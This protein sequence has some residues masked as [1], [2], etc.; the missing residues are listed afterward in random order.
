MGLR[1]RS[2]CVLFITILFFISSTAS[3]QDGVTVTTFTPPPPLGNWSICGPG[4]TFTIE[5]AAL[6]VSTGVQMT[7]EL[8]PGMTY[9]AN[10]LSPAATSEN[11]TN[12]NQPVF[13]LPDYTVPGEMRTYTFEVAMN[14]STETYLVAGGN[15]ANMT[16][17]IDAN[18]GSNTINTEDPPFSPFTN[19]VKIPFLILLEGSNITP[20]PSMEVGD[21]ITRTFTLENTGVNSELYEFT[22]CM[23]YDTDINITNRTLE[24]SAVTLDGMGCLTVN[25]TNA[26]SLGITLPFSEGDRYTWSEDVELV[27]CTD[28]SSQATVSWGCEGSDCQT[29][30]LPMGVQVNLNNP[31]YTLASNTRT[32]GS[33]IDD[34]A[35]IHTTWNMTSGRAYDLELRA[36]GRN[37][38]TYVDSSTV[39]ININ[40]AGWTAVASSSYSSSS[41]SSICGGQEY[42]DVRFPVAAGP[43]DA[44]QTI[45]IR[46]VIKTCCPSGSNCSVQTGSIMGGRSYLYSDNGCGN[47]ANINNQV[48]SVNMNAV[49][50]DQIPSFIS[51]GQTLTWIYNLDNIPTFG[52]FGSSG[53]VCMDVR[54]DEYLDYQPNSARWLDA[55]GN[56]PSSLIATETI[57]NN[58]DGS[59]DIRVCFDDT[60]GDGSQVFFEVSY[61]CVPASCGGSASTSMEMGYR[62]G[63]G[64]CTNNCLVTFMCEDA[65]TILGNGCCPGTCTGLC[66]IYTQAQRSCF[67]EPDNDNDGCPDVGGTIDLNNV[68]WERAVYGDELTME[69]WALVN[70]AA[71]ESYDS[72]DHV[73]LDLVFPSDHG[74]GSSQTLQIYDASAST[75]YSCAP[76]VFLSAD[77]RTINYYL[78]TDLIQGCGT[79][80]AD[81]A[82]EDGDT[83]KIIGS[84]TNLS[85]PGCRLLQ[86]TADLDWYSS[87]V[88]DPTSA[89]RQSCCPSIDPT[90]TQVGSTFSLEPFRNNAYGC[91]G[92][93][94]GYEVNFCIGGGEYRFQP[95]PYEI[96]NFFTPFT[97]GLKLPPGLTLDYLELDEIRFT[98]RINQPNSPESDVDITSLAQIAN[99]YLVLDWEQYF[100]DCTDNFKP[101]GGYNFSISGQFNGSCQSQPSLPEWFFEASDDYC[102]PALADQ[103][104]RIDSFH[105]SNLNIII[106][107]LTPSTSVSLI[108]PEDENANWSFTITETEG[109]SATNAWA[110]FYDPSGDILPVQLQRGSTTINP[111]NGV[112]SLGTIG[113]NAIVNYNLEASYTSCSYDSLM[114]LVGW[115]CDAIPTS[116]QEALQG[117]LSC[118][119][120]TLFLY[121]QPRLGS[122]QQ[123]V[124]QQPIGPIPAC[125]PFP[126]EIE[127]TNVG[128]PT[129]YEPFFEI[130][131]PYTAGFEIDTSTARACYPC[132]ISS[133]TY[134]YPIFNPTQTLYTPQGIKYIWDF[135]Q[136]ITEFDWATLQGMQGQAQ[137]DQT[138]R[139]LRIMFDGEINC[140]FIGGDF[141]RVRTRA[142]SFCGEITQTLLQ[143]SVQLELQGQ[144]TPYSSVINLNVDGQPVNGC[145][146]NGGVN[147]DGNIVFF[148]NTDGADSLIVA[149][150]PAFS[151]NSAIF[152]AAQVSNFT[153]RITTYGPTPVDPTVF[154]ELRW[155]INSGITALTPISFQINVNLD[156]D[157]I[158]CDDDNVVLIRTVQSSSV[159]CNSTTCSALA[160]TGGRYEEIQLVKDQYVLSDFEVGTDCGIN[161]LQVN[162]LTISNTGTQDISEDINIDIYYDADD[163]G[164]FSTG[165][166]RLHAGVYS[167]VIPVGGSRNYS[168]PPFAV[169]PAQTCKLIAVASGC[170]CDVASIRINSIL[171]ANAGVDQAGCS[172]D[173]FNLGC[174]EDL[175]ANGFTYEWFGLGGVPVDSLSS[176][177]DPNPVLSYTHFNSDTLVLQ[178][179]LVTSHPSGVCISA[180]TVALA[181]KGLA[182]EDG[183]SLKVCADSL[184][185]L[186]GPTGFY[187]YR[188]SP[189][190][191]V[192][193]TLDPQS[194]V[195]APA[196]VQSYLLIYTDLTGCQSAF[197]QEVRGV[198]CTDLELSKT[199]SPTAANIGEVLTYTLTVINQGPNGASMVEVAD[200]L[201]ANLSL[202]STLPN[203]GSYNPTTNIWTIPGILFPG[204]TVEMTIYAQL[205]AGG[206]TFNVAEISAM[207]E[208]D[209]DSTPGNDDPSEDDQDGVCVGVPVALSCREAKTIGIADEFSSYQWFRDGIAI[210]GATS[211]SLAITEP[212]SYAVQVDGGACPYGNCCPFVVTEE[213]CANMGDYV[214]EDYDQDGVQDVG[215]NPIAGVTVYLIDATTGLTYDSAMTDVNGNYNFIEIP[216]GN[217]QISFDVATNANGYTYIG[218]TQNAGVNDTLDSDAQAGTG[219]IPTFAF[220][221]SLGDNTTF[222]AGFVPVNTIGDF[223]WVD[224]NQDGLQSIGEGGVEGVSV[225]LYD[226]NTNT[227]VATTT[228]DASGQ[229]LFSN[230]AP[231]E[232]YVQFDLS[233]AT[234]F[235]TYGFTAIGAGDGTNDSEV[236]ANGVGTTFTFDP[237]VGSDL[238]HDAG[239]VPPADLALRKEVDRVNPAVGDTI[240]FTLQVN[241]EGSVQATGIEVTD[242]LPSGF[243]YISD[244]SGG[245]YTS[246]TG[247]WAVGSLAAG[248]S[249]SLAIAVRVL[250]IGIYVNVAEISAM[251]SRDVDSDPSTGP[252]TDDLGD[253]TSDDDEDSLTV[254]VGGN[255]DLSLNK[256]LAPG[257]SSMI[258]LGDDVTYL[259]RIINEG[260]ID[261]TNIRVIDYIPDGS[262]LSTADTSGWVSTSSNTAEVVIPGPLAMGDTANLYIVLKVIYGASDSTLTNIAEIIETFDENGDP[263]TD[264]DS[265][266]NNRIPGE[267]DQEEEEIVLLDHDPNGFIYCDKT[268]YI[269]TGGTISVTG[270]S[271]IPNDEVI[272]ISDGSNGFY[273]YF[274][275][276]PPG[277][278]TITYT[279]PDGVTLSS[280]RLPQTGPYDVSTGPDP[281]VFGSDTLSNFLIDTAA[282]SNPYYLSFDVEVGDPYIQLNNLPVTCVFIG[283]LVC[284]D[285]DANNTDD[286]TEPGMAN[287]TVRLVDC[288]DTTTVL[289]Q[290]TSDGNGNYR[291][292]GLLPGNYRVQFITPSGYAPVDGNMLDANGFAPCVSLNWGDCD[293]SSTVCFTLLADLGDYAWIDSDGD[294]IQDA[295]EAGLPNVEVILFD[296]GSGTAI[297]TVYTDTNGA[298]RFTNIPGGDYYLTFDPTGAGIGNTVFSP[299]GAGNVVSDSDADASGQTANFNF[300]PYNGN[301][302]TRD[303]GISP[304]ADIGNYVWID[305]N[306]DGIQDA[307]ETGLDAVRV[308][309]FNATTG[310]PIDTVTT[311][312]SGAYTFTNIPGGDYFIG[313]D[314]S[315]SPTSGSNYSFSPTNTGNGANDSDASSSGF[316]STFT[317]NPSVGNDLNRDAGVIP[318]ANIGDFVWTDTDGDGIQDPGESGLEGVTVIL[319]NGDTGLPVDTVVTTTDGSY[320]FTS[321]PSGNYYVDFDPT[322]SEYGNDFT[323][324]PQGTGTGS[325]DSDA[326]A[327]G[328]TAVFAFNAFGGSITTIDGGII[329]TP[330]IRTVKSI[331]TTTLLSN[332]NIEIQ[333]AIGIRNTGP[334]DL[335]NISLLDDLSTQLGA[336]FVGLSGTTPVVIVAST[337]TNTPALDPAYNGAGSNDIFAGASTNLLEPDQEITVNVTIAI[338][339]NLATFPLNNQATASGEGLDNNGNPLEDGSGNPLTA[340]DVSDSGTDYTGTNPGEPGDQGTEDDPTPLDCA[341]ANII[342]TGE[343]A[344]I[345]PGGS[346]SLSVVSDIVG[347]SFQWR[348]VGSS[349]II[350]TSANPTFSNLTSTTDYEVTVINSTT[351]CYYDFRDTTTINVYTNPSVAPAAN[352]VLNPDCSPANLTLN[353]NATAGSGTTLSYSWTGP[354]N[355]SSS[356]QNPTLNNATTLNNGTYNLTVTDEHGCNAAGSVVVSGIQNSVTQPL[357][358]STAPTCDGGVVVLTIAAYSGASVDYV[359]T[360]PDSTNVSGLNTNQLTISPVDSTLHEGDYSVEV[361]VD[362]CVVNSDTFNLELHPTPTAAP[363][364]TAGSLCEGDALSLTANASGAL[365]YAWNGPNGFSSTAANPTIDNITVA[366]NGTYVLTVSNSEGCS[367]TGN[368]VVGNITLQPLLPTI[369]SNGPVCEDENITLSIQE[370]YTG[371]V[372]SYN[373]TNGAGTSIGNSSSLS[374]AASAATAISPYRVQVIVD[375]CSSELSAPHEVMVNTLPTAVASNGG[376][377]C[378]GESGQLLGNTVSG[379]SYEWRISGSSTIISTEQNPIILGLT[380]TTTY[381]LTVLTNGCASDPVSTTTLVVDPAPTA[382]PTFTYTLNPDC[383]PS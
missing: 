182:I 272:I 38:N 87:L 132:D 156:P 293:T 36:Q 336:A 193:D 237:R 383:S 251:D 44:P 369:T 206:S 356:L 66:N 241:N 114:V 340:T 137:A 235:D 233:T 172:S 151:F 273:E 274:E 63:D 140:D 205:T 375:G 107:N 40:G 11:V 54:L 178:Y 277:V 285:T 171:T 243:T 16:I 322:G 258:D 197:R 317:F 33:C 148:G 136:L 60:Y 379:A 262:I 195:V 188:W 21:V 169:T 57:T 264:I 341:P 228:T 93:E 153:P 158:L 7:L 119:S 357:I 221:A 121:M 20:I 263:V 167:G 74:L 270:P 47:S 1:T 82:Y 252:G 259:I 335:T 122:I 144:T 238:S 71:T 79:V 95:F 19:S 146:A 80:P 196:G 92:A 123:E 103:I 88:S 28:L 287:V 222:D 96:R 344:G 32:Y 261:A 160:Q 12:P 147:I 173:D 311:D 271:G 75:Y 23:T 62:F 179:V 217:Y 361:T 370:V 363:S 226:A 333:Y 231:G 302:L 309:L 299:T 29:D 359:W 286:G 184:I 187:N 378:P 100:N 354:N 27:G 34:G 190:T 239:V 349:T 24:G 350:S 9:V 185:S 128:R 225:T 381:E 199:V 275:V 99:G 39:E 149:L 203:D 129:L 319:Y 284:E 108:Q 229:Y 116:D 298:Y 81:F 345:C 323:F 174:G 365:N 55:S 42:T 3:G 64:S 236:G 58:M 201:P 240:I 316:T 142:R 25:S 69:S 90:Y 4:E 358:N 230:Q 280:T 117:G 380:S 308:I 321:V 267:D 176:N 6:T 191:G 120:D 161:N 348:I 139:K 207:N 216:S 8:D 377:I 26:A 209:L 366:N 70:I 215:E 17:A 320:T 247:V 115:D 254:R 212:G 327:N 305:A 77:N 97:S 255:F 78:S 127:I 45:E 343:P 276:G 157:A 301:D 135:E 175:R 133:P 14:C 246:S 292:D 213:P 56:D 289:R 10:S 297:D 352:Y 194:T 347:A 91:G 5:T 200:T 138:L 85:N 214:W 46:Y 368:V 248:D 102:S 351:Q 288:A 150:P 220:D 13:N 353:A 48:G 260:D 265:E 131:I 314:P 31:S 342:I 141:L 163:S 281:T 177:T 329:P 65:T 111:T 124:I 268:G 371:T 373:W 242:Q 61:S 232:Y 324:T 159:S 315:T 126:M 192:T 51:D 227:P 337:A 330:A 249:T 49:T 165:D 109:Q 382:A 22:I 154:Q 339:P 334:V 266:P 290:T 112:Y 355:F 362:G 278:Y 374:F 269:I 59:T 125:T 256:N 94:F 367:T 113:G 145:G 346:I 364:A 310:A 89:Q 198:P 253:G 326:D 130:F 204:D 376:S 208:G 67:G 312:A 50:S 106:P 372:V 30:I 223:V 189:T 41:R 110:V 211:D 202:L 295:G 35:T 76:N 318:T 328:Q 291:F 152:N 53:S 37:T 332:G 180:D 210:S 250:P 244:N 294:G 279:H 300:N 218:A 296:V 257:Q 303:A 164:G 313:F 224:S 72:L 105:N 307:G 166:V 15:E 306:G 360:L 118:G 101:N 43:I 219:L 84:F 338:N 183:P 186:N 245:T 331:L 104:T 134:N 282:A 143:N 170:T 68:K 304:V 155:A 325:N 234:G 18:E 98:Q 162:N 73:F 283:A 52:N 168:T 2:T 86:T 83:V 181:L